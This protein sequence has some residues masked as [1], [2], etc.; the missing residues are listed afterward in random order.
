MYSV[1]LSG[2]A[3]GFGA[4]PR[5]CKSLATLTP[6]LP[7][8]EELNQFRN[9]PDNDVVCLEGDGFLG[10]TLRFDIS[11]RKAIG[12]KTKSRQFSTLYKVECQ[13]FKSILNKF[14]QNNSGPVTIGETPYTINVVE[15]TFTGSF[16]GKSFKETI[17]SQDFGR[18]FTTQNNNYLKALV[19]LVYNNYY[20]DSLSSSPEGTTSGFIPTSTVNVNFSNLASSTGLYVCS[21][22]DNVFNTATT[23]TNA[24]NPSSDEPELDD[25]GRTKRKVVPTPAP[26]SLEDVPARYFNPFS[27]LP[28]SFNIFQT[29]RPLTP[30]TKEQVSL[31]TLDNFIFPSVDSLN[32]ILGSYSLVNHSLILESRL[33]TYSLVPKNYTG[34]ASEITP[35]EFSFFEDST[36]YERVFVKSSFLGACIYKVLL[37]YIQ[38]LHSQRISYRSLLFESYERKKWFNNGLICRKGSLKTFQKVEAQFDVLTTGQNSTDKINTNA[39]LMF[40]SEFGDSVGNFYKTNR[41]ITC[42]VFTSQ[43]ELA[44]ANYK[45]LFKNLE[46]AL[47]ETIIISDL[48]YVALKPCFERG[49]VV[50]VSNTVYFRGLVS[51]AGSLVAGP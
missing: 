48:P 22:L 10:I 21:S 42:T 9:K 38:E 29:Q 40:T 14:Y 50:N 4:L 30:E 31:A 49:N 18:N 25:K 1:V 16:N 41:F 8:P 3:R 26:T 2:K 17:S 39:N 35:F 51:N 36:N 45:P 19:Y 5:N 15:Q 28:V 37:Q 43:M 7:L 20:V 27:A 33:T 47:G 12:V 32:N 46:R 24:S 34:D 23:P 44:D 11:D 13:G 6:I